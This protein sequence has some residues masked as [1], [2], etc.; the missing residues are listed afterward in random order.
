MFQKTMELLYHHISKQTEIL[1]TLTRE[2]RKK[3]RKIKN[4]KVGLQP[5]HK[6]AKTASDKKQKF[7]ILKLATSA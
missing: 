7:M 6:T 5:R 1:L 2:R 4:I 3:N